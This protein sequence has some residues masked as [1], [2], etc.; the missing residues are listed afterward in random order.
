[1]SRFFVLV[2]LAALL[3]GAF[4]ACGGDSGSRRAIDIVQTNDG[5]T[6]ATISL[7]AGEQVTFKVKNDG[8]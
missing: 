6:P 3:V 4:A 5:C 7:K 1:M 8:D 2:P